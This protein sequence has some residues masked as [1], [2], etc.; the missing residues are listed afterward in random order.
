MALFGTYLTNFISMYPE[1]LS[2]YKY[3]GDRLKSVPQRKS[4]PQ[5]V[6][7]KNHCTYSFHNYG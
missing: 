1:S 5:I 2:N 3:K 7:D 6:D 4:I